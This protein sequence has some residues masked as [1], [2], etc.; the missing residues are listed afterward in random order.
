[1]EPGPLYET[2]P[3]TVKK[4]EWKA[5]IGG[6]ENTF[7]YPLTVVNDSWILRTV[8]TFSQEDT[9]WVHFRHPFNHSSRPRDPGT[10]KTFR[11]QETTY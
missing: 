11:A 3:R 8:K 4:V 6:I 9:D 10:V 7:R 2:D 1:M 5:L